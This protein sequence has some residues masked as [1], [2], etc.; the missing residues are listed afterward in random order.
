MDELEQN[1]ILKELRDFME[2][3]NKRI[4]DLDRKIETNLNA[5]EYRLDGLEGEISH[6][7]G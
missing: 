6:I 3:V 2:K 5:I 7:T 1:S 4:D